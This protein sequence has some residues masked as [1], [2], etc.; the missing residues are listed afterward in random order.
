MGRLGKLQSIAG[1]S[2]FEP[3]LSA[4]TGRSDKIYPKLK[5]EKEKWIK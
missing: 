5:E 2:M 1:N 3:S 4:D